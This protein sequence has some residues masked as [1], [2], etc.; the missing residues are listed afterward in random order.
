MQPA[1][2]VVLIQSNLACGV[3]EVLHSDILSAR[4]WKGITYKEV[5]LM[6]WFFIQPD[7]NEIPYSKSFVSA[8]TVTR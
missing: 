1:Q 2:I 4:S 6:R 8:E 5:V 7:A 3:V